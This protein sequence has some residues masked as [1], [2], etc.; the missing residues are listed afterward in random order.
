MEHVQHVSCLCVAYRLCM[1]EI[2]SKFR[3]VV[4]QGLIFWGLVVRVLVFL[5]SSL[6]GLIKINENGGM[7]RNQ[8]PPPARPPPRTTHPPDNSPL[9]QFTPGQSLPEQFSL[10]F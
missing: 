8:H 6:H 7:W 9:G 5:S 4:V 3:G 1:E 2:L 10:L